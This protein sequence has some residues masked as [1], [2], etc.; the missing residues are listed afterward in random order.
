ML[1]EIGLF[2]E[3]FFA[4]CE[5]TDL[6]LRARI[7]GWRCRYAPTAIAKHHYSGSTG[8]HSPFK[9]FHVERNRIW[10]VVKCFPLGMAVASLVYTMARYALQLYATLIGRGAAA[11]LAAQQSPWVLVATIARAWM[12]ALARL[13]EMWRRRRAIHSAARIGRR[14]LGRLLRVHRVRLSELA[15]KD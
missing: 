4:Y 11:K 9:A 8:P 10:V 3:D 12:S 15:L 2:D 14:E 6:G 1:D 5:D 13:P 7:A